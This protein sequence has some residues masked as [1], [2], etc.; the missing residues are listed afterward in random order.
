M[1]YET[2]YVID[3]MGYKCNLK[4]VNVNLGMGEHAGNEPPLCKYLPLSFSST[5]C[6]SLVWR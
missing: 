6:W 2:D 1:F 4:Y 5:Q 3:I